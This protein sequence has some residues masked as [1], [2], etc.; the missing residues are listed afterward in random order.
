MS[1][2]T[3]TNIVRVRFPNESY[4]DV[5]ND[6]KWEEFKPNKI[7]NDCVFGWYY[8]VYVCVDKNDYEEHF[9]R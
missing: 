8:D 5:I 2:I 7:F 9:N 4:Y 6:F 1:K 3:Q